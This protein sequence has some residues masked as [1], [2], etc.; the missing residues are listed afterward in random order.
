[1]SDSK[2]IKEVK[3][4]QDSIQSAAGKEK[5]ENKD[6]PVIQE[7]QESQ[8]KDG[9]NVV[10][11]MC[12]YSVV[13]KGI[14]RKLKELGC[15]VSIV[16]QEQG[17]IPKMN[18]KGKQLFILYLPNKITEDVLKL[19]WLEHIYAVIQ[20]MNGDVIVI[21]DKC[22]RDDLAGRVFDMLHVGWLD[23]P[24]KMEDLELAVTEGI[25]PGARDKR[26]K[27]ILIVDDDPS[28]ARMV[29]E[30]LK[31]VYQVSIVTAGIQAITFLAKNTVA[32]ILLDYEMPVVDGPQVF[33]MLR[34]DP[35]TQGIP[36]VFLTGVG[37]KEQVERVLQLKPNG[38]VLKS[39]TREKLLSYLQSKL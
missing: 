16:T 7:N 26:R 31:D 19:N 28:Y 6:D 22:D 8:E 15:N 24:L 14:E 27:H 36:V 11:V 35:S 25:L 4:V 1:M 37:T 23:R 9:K 12:K 20:E 33:Q 34:Q 18:D 2:E 3:E 39:T 38:Y 32:L 5:Q 10:I 13:V 17:T 29:R 21:G 30:W